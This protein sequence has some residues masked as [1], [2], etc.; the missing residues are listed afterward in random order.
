[1]TPFDQLLHLAEEQGVDKTLDFLEHRFRSEQEYFKLFEVLKMRCR[2]KLGLPL[3][4]GPQRDAIENEQ[5]SQL[6]DCLLGACRDVGSL[7]LKSGRL[8]EGWMYLQPVGDREFSEKVIQTIEP[9]EE[10]IDTIIEIAVTQGAAPTYGF[11]LLLNHYG[12]CN[13]ITTFDTQAG[14]FDKTTQKSMAELLL[15]HL[16][17][18]LC[19]NLCFTVEQNAKPTTDSSRL[20]SILEANPWL[21]ADGAHHIDTT[22]LA[23]VMRIARLVDEPEDLQKALELADYGEQLHPDFQYPS[24]PPFEDTYPDHQQYFRCLLG[25]D[26]S[27]AIGHFE[28]KCQSVDAD[29][30]GGIA[31]ETLIDLLV[32][33]GRNQQAIELLT[34]P[35]VDQFEPLGIAPQVLEVAS[36]DEELNVVR[37]FY[38]SQD[39][40]LGFA[41]SILK[42]KTPAV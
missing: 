10:N 24:P 37:E 16:Y 27:S 22:H 26:P 17:R 12:T 35:A 28:K 4:Y 21:I 6:E 14:R 32:R 25:R 30:H 23:S 42:T 41:A 19:D 40:L 29:Q 11:K 38:R 34:D 8:Q 2:H 1:M 15:R 33:V 3:L 36:S 7:L 13:A 5:Q 31:Y 20:S 18:E 9:N 39:D